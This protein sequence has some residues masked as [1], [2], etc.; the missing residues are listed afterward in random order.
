MGFLEAGLLSGLGQGLSQVAAQKRED[1]MNA[2]KRQYQ[3]EDDATAETQ[4]IAK[5]G[6]EN[7]FKV[8]ILSLA[9]QYKREEGETEQKYK[10]RL[11]QLQ[12]DIEARH[13]TQRGKAA[14]TLAEQGAKNAINLEAFKASVE[15]DKE[16]RTHG[17]VKSVEALQDGS[18]YIVYN[19]GT[20]KTD[21]TVKLRDNSAGDAGGGGMIAGAQARAGGTA[22]AAAKSAAKPAPAKPQAVVDRNAEIERRLNTDST[23]GKGD[24]EGETMSGPGGTRAR[25][26]KGQWVLIVGVR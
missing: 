5:E 20:D 25:W 8:G 17:G 18:A 6:R 7:T 24:Y 26:S 21:N 9:N 1:A 4:A 13:I 2:L 16:T 14:V 10:E 11:V 19:D 3:K 23:I 22:P 15:K 12:A